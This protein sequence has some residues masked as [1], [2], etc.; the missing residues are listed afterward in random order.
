MGSEMKARKAAFTLIELL[1][2]VAS[3]AVLLAI[4]LGSTLGW[5]RASGLRASVLNVR[6]SLALARQLAVTH[7]TPVS[8]VFGN[9]SSPGGVRVIMLSQPTIWRAF[10][11][12]PTTCRKAL[13]ST[14][15]LGPALTSWRTVPVQTPAT[16]AVVITEI[17][18]FNYLAATITVSRLT[19]VAQQQ[20][21][22]HRMTYARDQQRDGLIM[23]EA[24]LAVVVLAIGVLA[25]FMLFSVGLNA[26]TR[27]AGDTQAAIFAD[28]VFNTLRAE[29]TLASTDEPLG[30]VLG[31]LRRR[32]T[33][34]PVAA[35]G[36]DGVWA[37]SN[38]A[39][40]AGILC[41]TSTPISRSASAS[42]RTSWITRSVLSGGDAGAPDGIST[43]RVA[44]TLQVWE[45]IFGPTNSDAGSV[46]YTEFDNPGDLVN[47]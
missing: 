12:K 4:A 26:R 14:Q 2:V 18:R 39:I 42:I 21:C 31:R 17:R 15:R 9:I 28:S 25:A 29:S 37:N 13:S 44:V 1:C 45:G 6:S 34:L 41:T 8:F 30:G 38:I 35:G 43:N 46:L 36:P 22:Q 5:G 27:A 7:S 20:A 24:A 19:G 10:W 40:R 11:A 23:V 32:R 33:N 16:Q 3:C 47:Q